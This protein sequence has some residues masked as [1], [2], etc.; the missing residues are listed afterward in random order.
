MLYYFLG[1]ITGLVLAA[2]NMLAYRREVQVTLKKL[3]SS[4]AKI[5]DPTN[6]LDNIDL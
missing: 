1:I 4:R 3:F 5:I 6:P 2:V